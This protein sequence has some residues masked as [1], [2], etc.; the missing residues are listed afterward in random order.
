MDLFGRVNVLSIGRKAYCLVIIDDYSRYTWVYFLSHKDETA[1]LLKRFI[2]LIENQLTKKVK[3]IRSDNGTE[4]KNNVMDTFCA[5]KGIDHQYSA[6][7]TP[8]QNGV[9]ERRNRTLIEAA[10]T[11]LIDSKLPTFF[12]VEAINTACY[13]QNHALVNKRHMKTPYEVILGHK[14]SVSDFRIFGCPCVL[15][16]MDANGKFEAKG[17]EC[18]FVGYAK[19]TS[20]RVYN[21]VTKKVIETYDVRWLEENATDARVGPD[22]LYDY[23]ELFKSFNYVSSV[24]PDAGV[25]LPKQPLSFGETEDEVIETK[26]SPSQN[27]DHPRISITENPVSTSQQS[28]EGAPAVNNSSTGYGSELF[29]DPIP[30]EC[31]VRTPMPTRTTAPNEQRQATS[32]KQMKCQH[33]TLLYL[34]VFRETTQLRTSLDLLMQEFKPEAN[35]ETLICVCTQAISHK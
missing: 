34:L 8:Q 21:K 26:S 28:P 19:G 10:R 29:P 14:P 16:L 13:V 22:W 24:S 31:L 9:A 25:S 6:A 4:F 15:L 2:I 7:R 35:L 23:A 11:M 3:A 27:I 20:Y 1:G 32:M 18:Y 33:L 5:E 30:E 12:W 17:D